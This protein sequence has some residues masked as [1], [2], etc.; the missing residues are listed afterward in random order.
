MLKSNN[1]TSNPW[2]MGKRI[3]I[4]WLGLVCLFLALLANQWFFSPQSPI[5]T[6]ILKLLPK[7]Q[8]NP[9]AEQ[10]FESVSNNLSDKVV[11]VVSATEPNNSYIAAEA[12]A[13]SLKSTGLFSEVVGKVEA[14]QQS[15]W[16]EYYYQHR[17]QQLTPEQRVRL[18][19]QPQA[20]V[21]Y[22]LQSLYNPFSGVTGKELSNDPFL[23]F[24]DYLSQLTQL[25]NAFTLNNGFLTTNY[26]DQQY[27]LVSATLKDSPYSLS[28]QNGVSEI[29]RIEQ[30]LTDQYDAQFYHTGVLFYAEFGTQSA[31]SE[32]STIGLFSLL[33]V[34]VLII[35]VFR[36]T[37]PLSLALL[38]ITVGLVAAL[39]VTTW[40]FGTIHLFSLVFGASLIGVSI[41][42][43]F[44]YLTERLA[45]GNQWDSRQGLKHIFAAITMGLLTSLIGYMGMLI[46]PFPGL[47]QL[48][49]FSSIGL[50][51]A[52]ATVVAW[53]P[54]LAAK[55]AKTRPLPGL[56]IWQSW[57]TLWSKP[58]V[59][60]SLPLTC[61]I[62]AL[63]PLANLQYDDDIRQLQAMPESLKQQEAFISQLSGLNSSQQMIVVTAKNDELLLQKLESFDEQLALWQ[64][65]GVIEGY[66]S[67]TQ[68]IS[69]TSTQQRDF[70][71]IK[72]LYHNQGTTLAS[73]LKLSS[74]PQFEQSFESVSLQDYL[75]HTVS[76]PV[77]FLYVGQVGDHT[78]S[79]VLLKN[80]ANVDIIKEFVAT[81]PNMIYLNKAEEISAL[82]AEYRIKV[83][84][85]IAIALVV[86]GAVLAK[87]YGVVHTAKILIPSLIACIAG[88]AAASAI[89]STLNLFNL[90][91]LILII[92]IG[93]DYTLFF[94]E[95]ARSTSTLLAIT[96]SAMTTLLSFGLLSLSQTHAIHSFG[97][98]VLC[99]IFVAWLLSPLA[100]KER[101]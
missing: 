85:L 52:Y 4:A 75:S 63:L 20:Q 97:I 40:L 100:I 68:F 46:A 101:N 89:G 43:A 29:Q 92:G 93:I 34:V 14:E 38:S 23:I 49:L 77:R 73:T 31:K 12:L 53:Y 25:N 47:Q 48:A 83:M 7:N 6:N 36:S 70:E 59:R 64:E 67:L 88:L 27:V 13:H 86:I 81:Q 66:Q 98:T 35:G 80:L 22:V 57:L 5:E 3:A 90:L 16:A 15:R 76:K 39:A 17:F 60:R 21:Q 10:A 44:H 58:I 1:S 8:Q 96:L 61:L 45:A 55:P 18:T 72:Q 65:Q 84:E 51:A 62:V 74:S 78:A 42:Y 9:V 79:V 11:F 50:A 82:F 95:K 32:I 69:S 71:L 24:R 41:D 91:A 28:A 87:R 54:V 19:D 56:T 33:G 2:F 30:A 37:A 94:A 99:G 26:Q